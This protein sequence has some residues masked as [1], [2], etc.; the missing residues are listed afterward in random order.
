MIHRFGQHRRRLAPEQRPHE[1]ENPLNQAPS[2][3]EQHPPDIRSNLLA[4]EQSDKRLSCFPSRDDF[5]RLRQIEH[6]YLAPDRHLLVQFHAAHMAVECY[7]V[8][9]ERDPSAASFS[10][11]GYADRLWRVGSNPGI[12]LL[13]ARRQEV[14]ARNG[15]RS[16]VASVASQRADPGYEKEKHGQADPAGPMGVVWLLLATSVL[17]WSYLRHSTVWL[18]FRAYHADR[19]ESRRAFAR[20]PAACRRLT[21]ASQEQRIAMR[22]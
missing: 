14:G 21:A 17:V 20:R 2:E 5:R 10:G 9:V 12:R 11:T 16:L 7:G 6:S 22:V 3:R 13:A 19:P 4:Q 1:A 15:F 8:D 18:A